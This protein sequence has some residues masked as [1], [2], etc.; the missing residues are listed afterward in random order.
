MQLLVQL[1]VAEAAAALVEVHLLVD[2]AA[3]AAMVARA[4]FM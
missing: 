4:I 3:Q 2:L 1:L